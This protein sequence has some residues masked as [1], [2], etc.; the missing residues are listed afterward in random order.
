MPGLSVTDLPC[1]VTTIWSA[2]QAKVASKGSTLA[3]VLGERGLGTEHVEIQYVPS[4]GDW[5][6]A[7]TRPRDIAEV[8]TERVF[9]DLHREIWALL[10]AEVLKG[11]AQDARP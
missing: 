6:V 3:S 4:I 8:K 1:A 10:K 7:L 11:Y 9:Q 2:K 5:K